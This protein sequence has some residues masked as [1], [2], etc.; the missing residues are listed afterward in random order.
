MIPA[1]TLRWNIGVGFRQPDLIQRALLIVTS[2]FFTCGL[3]L[4]A[5]AQYLAAE[6]T[7]A[8]LDI[9][10]VLAEA[11]NVVPARH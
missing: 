6:K 8:C 3:L 11:P 9:C 5:G 4:Q 7:K 1:R 2:I 10:I